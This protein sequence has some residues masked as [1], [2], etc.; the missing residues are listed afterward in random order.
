[1]GKGVLL[2]S[3]AESQSRRAIIRESK[4]NIPSTARGRIRSCS[5]SSLR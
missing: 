3:H 4:S 2:G 5:I 1:M